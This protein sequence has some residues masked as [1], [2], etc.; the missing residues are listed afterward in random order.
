MASPGKHVT[1]SSPI[2]GFDEVLGVEEGV[3][4]GWTLGNW[5]GRVDED[6]Y[7]VGDFDVGKLVGDS[8]VGDMVGAFDVGDMVGDFDVGDLV[9]DFD[10]GSAVGDLDVGDAVGDFDV[11]DGVN[12][13]DMT[14]IGFGDGM[15][16]GLFGL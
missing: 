5:E 14:K 15:G 1:G 9:G 3:W 10:V 6:G 16:E 7:I 13:S 12:G 2:G 11:G 8:D 4:I